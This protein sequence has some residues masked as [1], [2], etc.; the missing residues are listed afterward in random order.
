MVLSYLVN[1][2][3]KN[4][5]KPAINRQQHQQQQKQQQILGH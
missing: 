3:T 4:K 2:D 5:N 1:P